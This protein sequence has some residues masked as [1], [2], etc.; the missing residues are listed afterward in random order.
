MPTETDPILRPGRRR[1]TWLTAVLGLTALGA[2]LVLA[3][4]AK[5]PIPERT[6]LTAGPNIT[7]RAVIA[8]SLVAELVHRGIEA[9]IVETANTLDQLDAVRAREVDFAMVSSALELHRLYPELREV[10]PLF[11][12]ALH[13]LV[14]QEL[15]GS[16]QDGKLEG[17]HGLRVDLGPPRSAS[18]LLS[19][20]VLNFARIR[21]A[22][23]PGP[24]ACR[25]EQFELMT[26]LERVGNGERET[27]PDAIFHLGS[28]PS[29]IASELIE[30][31]DYALVSLPFANAFRLA[32]MISDDTRD[33]SDDMIERRST[34]EYILPPFLYG[35]SPPIPAQPLATVG[36]RLVLVAH[37]DLP[38]KLV[39]AVVETV[40]AT[41]FA[42]VP[43]PPLTR[44][45]LKRPPQLPL[46]AGSIAYLA[47]EH[48]IFAASDVDRLANGL[49]VL[50][51]LVG[52]GLFAW[53]AW[54]QR[55]RSARDAIF[56]GYQLEVAAIEKRIAE[57][58]LAAQ[59]ELEPLV[60]MQRALLKLKSDALARFSA[61][62]LGDQAS[63]SDLLTPLNSARDHVGSLLLHVRE[64]LESQA[65]RQGRSAE[66]VWDEAIE[67]S[68]SN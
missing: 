64:N 14:K 19:E 38:P 24:T 60:E 36:A 57:L 16:F 67:G 51:A 66:S 39:E 8:R 11:V 48:P 30:K 53:Q 22:S 6:T 52:A 26:L 68:E 44:A 5:E 1:A 2:A 34:I 59:L 9:E 18:A 61:G 37:R 3:L 32:G 54:R 15:A 43:D 50:G 17:L 58:E 20:D 63:V 4:R 21:C 12:E 27:L 42:R 56:T 29:K 13:L 46:H 35:T 7:S 10:T 25:R 23:E 33:R 31:H 41:R 65:R 47:R 40:L 62:E 45:L 28:V 49:S 55:A